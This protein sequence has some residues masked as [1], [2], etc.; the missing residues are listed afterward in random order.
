MASADIRLHRVARQLYQENKS[1]I[2]DIILY[3][4]MMKGK[5]DPQDIDMLIIFKN[6]INKQ[7]EVDLRKRIANKTV[8][9]NSITRAEL[10]EGNF[11]AGEGIYL[12]GKSMVRNQ[13][14]CDSLGFAA[15]AFIKYDISMVKGSRRVR[16]YY[17]LQGRNNNAG[18]LSSIGA[19]RYAES[20]VLCDYALIEQ[21]KPFFEQWNIDYSVTPALIPKRLH[22]VLFRTEK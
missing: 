15:V 3:G 9:I 11:I 10:E 4:S 13:L 22:K 20:V 7:I 1:D 19:R 18:F 8:E 12:E 6:T 5:T 16:F 17:A 21:A 14:I 2:E